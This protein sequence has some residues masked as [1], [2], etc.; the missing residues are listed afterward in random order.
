MSRCN[1]RN[2]GC[3]LICGH[4]AFCIFESWCA[5]SGAE[6]IGSD[7]GALSLLPAASGKIGLAPV[8]VLASVPHG[9]GPFHFWSAPW[10]RT[11]S[12]RRNRQFGSTWK[13]ASV[14]TSRR[15]M[16]S[17]SGENSVGISSSRNARTRRAGDEPFRSDVDLLGYVE[18]QAA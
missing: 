7:E 13:A 9:P 3:Q 10:V 17:R 1:R 2:E 12:S 14:S 18:T 6:A 15:P 11:R 8:A 5:S 16:R 4:Q